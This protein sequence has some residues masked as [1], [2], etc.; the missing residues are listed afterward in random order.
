MK[1]NSV[2]V[3]KKAA[4]V[5]NNVNCERHIQYYSH[6]EKY[7]K[8]N[9]WI[10]AE[11]FNV[12]KV[13]ICCC[14][15]HDVMHEK[16]LR[17]IEELKTIHFLES[18]IIIMGCQTKTHEPELIK[19]LAVKLIN[20][21]REEMLDEII[22]AQIP[23]AE[24]T[25]NNIFRPHKLCKIDE[26]NEYFHIK[27]A[28]GCLRQC[29][30]CVIN[31][32][33]GYINSTPKEEILRQFRKA[34]ER[35]NRRIYL[36]GEDTLAYGIDIDTDIIELTESLL[37]ID[38]HVELNFGSLHIRWL[39]KYAS[40]I[41]SLC[42]RGIVKELHVGLQHIND[43]L[44]KRMGRPCVF[45]E[46]YEIIK[47]LKKECAHLFLE[48]DILVGFPGETEEMFAE[49]VEFFKQDRCFDNVRHFGFSDV[50]GAPSYKFEDKLSPHE[51]V[52]RWERFDKIL[53]ERSSN[54]K[55]ESVRPSD[56]AFQLTHERDY[57]FCKDTFQ[58]EVE[59]VVDD[60]GLRQAKSKI[61][62]Q[63]EGDFGF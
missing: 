35:G 52:V 44:L 4:I 20:F 59:Q 32:A 46:I 12:D 62:Q 39:Q 22:N 24:I 2:L 26:K 58:D 45:S 49:L 29:T 50:R 47:T 54:Y 5:T 51:V 55:A 8:S 18:N 36:M 28:R 13:I 61:L 63:D 17:T 60:P 27:I 15:F 14:G 23:F 11:D 40:G 31:K 33:K 3:K 41:L 6:I 42:K 38:A 34:V 9:G 37:A 16:V 19:N 30:F 7:F 21:D 48:T 57:I 43:Q 1:N 10:I 56:V 25:P 53:R